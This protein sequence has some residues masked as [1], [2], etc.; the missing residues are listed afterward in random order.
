MHNKNDEMTSPDLSEGEECRLF[1]LGIGG[2][3]GM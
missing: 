3:R 2:F 1:Q